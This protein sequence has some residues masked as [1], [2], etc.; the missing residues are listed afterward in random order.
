MSSVP[1]RRNCSL[2]SVMYSSQNLAS[3]FNS[4]AFWDMYK[5]EN[6]NNDKFYSEIH[7]TLKPVN[8]TLPRHSEFSGP[9]YALT[10]Y[11]KHKGKNEKASL[12][13]HDPASPAD[14]RAED[15]VLD[16]YP[17]QSYT[18]RVTPSHMGMDEAVKNLVPERRKCR[19]P[20]ESGSLSIFGWYS[21]QSCLFEC[22]LKRA[23]EFCG[24]IGWDYPHFA[25]NLRV[26]HGDPYS[27]DKGTVCFAALMDSGG[28]PSQ[29]PDC[30]ASC[31]STSYPYAVKSKEINYYRICT[32]H[33]NELGIPDF[34][35]NQLMTK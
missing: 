12:M 15:E 22:Q 30:P 4:I 21:Q 20:K 3:T 10:L 2:M 34:V 13:V 28:M 33:I 11:V 17:G 5:K 35:P 14:M 26:C 24:C 16:L 7:E 29:C 19:L 32:E 8:D 1:L 27:T 6:A 9:G 25:P 23:Y 31:E 18:I